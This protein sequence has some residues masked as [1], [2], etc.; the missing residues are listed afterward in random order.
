MNKIAVIF[1]LFLL[2]FAYVFPQDIQLKSLKY[3]PGEN[4][5][6]F[7]VISYGHGGA[8]YI[9]IDFDIARDASAG[10]EHSFPVL[11]QELESI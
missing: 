2:T 9:S 7:P 5:T 1:L 3:Y 10:F 4:E 8:G 6:A 11:R